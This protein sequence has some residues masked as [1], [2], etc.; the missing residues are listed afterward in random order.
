LILSDWIKNHEC[1]N[2]VAKYGTKI[3]LYYSEDN[4][5]VGYGS[6]GRTELKYPDPKEPRVVGIIPMIAVDSKFKG[7]P[8]G[9]WQDRY[10]SAVLRQIISVAIADGQSLLSLNVHSCNLAAITFYE[11]HGFSFITKKPNREGNHRMIMVLIP[12]E[13]N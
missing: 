13:V 8:P 2:D 1:F 4:Q 12:Q 7:K 3:W 9:Q 11:R 5:L 6:Y 10:A